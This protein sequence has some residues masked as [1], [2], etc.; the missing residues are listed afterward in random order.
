MLELG[1]SSENHH[2][3]IGVAASKIG[4]DHLYCYG[5]ESAVT[6][7]SA[8]GIESYH[9]DDKTSLLD[10]LRKSLKVGDIVLFKGSRGMSLESIIKE[11][12]KI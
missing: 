2:R 7:K 12:D 6:A 10:S 3:K 9:F 8:D 4:V 1:V 5:P 11:L